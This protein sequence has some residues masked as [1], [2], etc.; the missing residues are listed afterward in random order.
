[1]KTIEV[2]GRI[3]AIDNL[4]ENMPDLT[5]TV[6][7]HAPIITEDGLKTRSELLAFID[8]HWK[9]GQPVILRLEIAEKPD[10]QDSY[11]PE[12]PDLRPA[13]QILKEN[14]IPLSPEMIDQT[15]RMWGGE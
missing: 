13:S 15:Q 14:A 7:V 11:P 5:M 6:V 9:A 12:D 8:E 4:R 1:M 3:K 10:P 2:S